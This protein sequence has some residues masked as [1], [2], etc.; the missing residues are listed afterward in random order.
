PYAPGYPPQNAGGYG[1]APPPYGPYNAAPA[2]DQPAKRRRGNGWIIAIVVVLALL[3]CG[4]VATAGVLLIANRD[5]DPVVTEPDVPSFPDPVDPAPTFDL[6]DTPD[7]PSTALPGLPGVAGKAVVYE[8]TG[9]GR[10]DINYVDDLAGEPRE[11]KNQ[12]LPWKHEFTSTEGSLLLTVSATSSSGD[13]DGIGCRITV[14]GKESA[15]NEGSIIGAFCIGT[16]FD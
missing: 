9:S 8:V 16:I 7:D 11:L 1:G 13:N 15:A 2:Y 4:G 14:D 6:P 12:K 10:A 5:D 3:F